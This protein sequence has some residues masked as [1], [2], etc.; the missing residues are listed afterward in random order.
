MGSITL[1]MT[2]A[3]NTTASEIATAEANGG[4]VEFFEAYAPLT[5][6]TT[7]YGVICELDG[8]RVRAAT[9]KEMLLSS[10]AKRAGCEDGII[11]VDGERVFVS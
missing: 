8:T 5:I 10:K 9:Q 7:P 11:T 3:A 6:E 2:N 4:T 1:P